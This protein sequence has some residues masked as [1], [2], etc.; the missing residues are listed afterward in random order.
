MKQPVSARSTA[1]RLRDGLL[2]GGLAAF[3]GIPGLL[4][5]GTALNGVWFGYQHGVRTAIVMLLI[6][7]GSGARRA[8]TT[9]C[10]NSRLQERMRLVSGASH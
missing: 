1:T 9:S 7:A 8:L 6:A 5:H 2:I 10:V 3:V 4:V